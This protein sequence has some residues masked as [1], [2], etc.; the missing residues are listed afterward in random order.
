MTP[1]NLTPEQQ[2]QAGG[3]A[4]PFGGDTGFGGLTIRDWF[5]AMAMQG[6]ATCAVQDMLHAGAETPEDAERLAAAAVGFI[7]NT[8]RLAYAAADAAMRQ[9]QTS[10]KQCDCPNCSPAKNS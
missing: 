2:K 3:R 4:I 5:A 1:V 6:A 10:P 8:V 9:R 7:S